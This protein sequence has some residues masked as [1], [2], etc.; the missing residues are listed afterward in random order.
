MQFSKIG[1]IND[2]YPWSDEKIT[3]NFSNFASIQF[4]EFSKMP[5]RNNGEKLARAGKI[6]TFV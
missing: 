2:M 6:S 5:T 3:I 1:S 4:L